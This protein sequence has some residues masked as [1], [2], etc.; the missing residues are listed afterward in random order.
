[1]YTAPFHP[2]D[3]SHFLAFRTPAPSVSSH[4]G[5]LLVLGRLLNGSLLADD[6]LQPL[7]PDVLRAQVPH[8]RLAAMEQRQGVDVLQLRVADALV[9]HQVEQLV[10]RVVQHL[11]VLPDKKKRKKKRKQMTNDYVKIQTREKGV[12]GDDAFAEQKSK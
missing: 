3:L 5:N 12:R 11:V 1:M 6:L 2:P 7:Q 8:A 10:G 4:R 9:H